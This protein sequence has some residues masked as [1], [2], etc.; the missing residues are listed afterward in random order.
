MEEIIQVPVGPRS[1]NSNNFHCT[2]VTFTTVTLKKKKFLCEKRP[3]FPTAKLPWSLEM[4]LY[5]RLVN[6]E[7]KEVLLHA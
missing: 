1:F 5:L 3:I 6:F 4:E 2:A 7:K